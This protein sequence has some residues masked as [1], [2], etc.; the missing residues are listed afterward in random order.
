[1]TIILGYRIVHN[2]QLWCVFG[3][4]KGGGIFECT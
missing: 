3:F 2:L 4:V 1:M